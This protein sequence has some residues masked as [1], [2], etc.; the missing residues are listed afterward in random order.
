MEI[1]KKKLLQETITA[2]MDDE[3]GCEAICACTNAA[4]MRKLLAENGVEATESEI[5][6]FKNEGLATI[7]KLRDSMNG[8]ISEAD[9]ENVAGGGFWRKL[10]RGAAATVLGA[11]GGFLAGIAC[12]ACPALAPAVTNVAIAYS[13]AAGVW[14]A[15][16]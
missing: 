13:V 6:A 14:I 4:E 9:L 5:E 16:G 1:T 10:G 8:E 12:A 2:L 11:G 7:N 3:K 15:A